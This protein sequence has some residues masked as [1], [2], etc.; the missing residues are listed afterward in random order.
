MAPE[1]RETKGCSQ[2]AL[3]TRGSC[4][5]IAAVYIFFA[6]AFR[7]PF[8]FQSVINPDESTLIIVGDGIVRGVVPYVEAWETKPVFVY[9]PYALFIAIFGRSVEAIRAGG[10][11]W[12]AAAAFFTYL[13]GYRHF[14]RKAAFIAGF[15]LVLFS[16]S[17]GLAHPRIPDAQAVMSEHIAIL[18]LVLIVS[19]LLS[20]RTSL[21]HHF[22]LGV[23]SASAALIRTN[24]LLL[25]P[26]LTLVLVLREW[27]YNRRLPFDSLAVFAAGVLL[28]YTLVVLVYGLQGQ[29]FL[30]V[31]SL[32][33]AP[34]VLVEHRLTKCG[35]LCN[36]AGISRK[37]WLDCL[38]GNWLIWLLFLVEFV[39]VSVGSFRARKG[40]EALW[41]IYFLFIVTL[42]SIVETGRPY[43]HYLLQLI[44]F[45]VFPAA[46]CLV[47]FEEGRRRVLALLLLILGIVS[48]LQGLVGEAAPVFAR[49]SEGESLHFDRGYRLAAYL[50]QKQVRD[51]YVFLMQETIVYWLVGAK[52]PTKYVQVSNIARDYLIKAVDGEDRG[53]LEELDKIFEK[54][55]L[56]VVIGR[57]QRFFTRRQKRRLR[58]K[59]TRSYQYKRRFRGLA[60]YQRKPDLQ[61]YTGTR[62]PD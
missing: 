20:G 10:T 52:L 32:Y 21:R 3:Q 39:V 29:L 43:Y 19:M 54:Q 31:K 57:Q 50:K 46:V 49:L 11:L 1:T 62:Q 15:F 28:P 55:P 47:R 8:F 34:L 27:R 53:S 13:A 33:S 30:L 45:M 44:P 25:I 36:L 4:F 38:H 26:A 6:F 22:V 23:V 40:S 5:L 7:V 61:T 51:R 16:S 2:E 14:G 35:S 12:I 9:L 24:L 41:A 60:V 48:P 59:L 56:Y 18:P 17:F 58:E 37:I 42:F